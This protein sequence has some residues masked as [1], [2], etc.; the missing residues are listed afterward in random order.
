MDSLFEQEK[1]AAYCGRL[2]NGLKEYSPLL[3]T[4][5][6]KYLKTVDNDCNMVSHKFDLSE[7]DKLVL[8]DLVI[9]HFNGMLMDVSCKNVL[10]EYTL[11][12]P[13]VY[14]GVMVPGTNSTL[15]NKIKFKVN[16]FKTLNK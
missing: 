9:K 8:G 12:K 16:Y 15:T 3:F 7:V 6:I 2:L 11:V 5:V 13:V 4:K 10:Y 1:Q 14:Q